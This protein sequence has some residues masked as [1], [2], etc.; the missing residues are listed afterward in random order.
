MREILS[1]KLPL[2]FSRR[3][4]E[5]P[6]RRIKGTTD[7]SRWI[8]FPTERETNIFIPEKCEFILGHATARFLIIGLGNMMAGR[9]TAVFIDRRKM[10]IELVN[11]IGEETHLIPP[12]CSRCFSNYFSNR[13]MPRLHSSSPEE[14]GRCVFL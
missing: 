12:T 4:D 14:R 6:L 11:K 7:E 3:C 8:H 2:G 1:Y 10:R 13:R 9:N 5:H